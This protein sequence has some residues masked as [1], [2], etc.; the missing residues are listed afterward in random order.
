MHYKKP[1]R[2]QKEI[3]VG[4]D[5]NPKEWLFVKQ[6]NDSYMQFRNVETGKLKN[7]DVYRKKR[8]RF[9]NE[10]YEGQSD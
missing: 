9:I 7:I 3:L 2:E 5:M 6:I 10:D 4:H 1:T 8:R